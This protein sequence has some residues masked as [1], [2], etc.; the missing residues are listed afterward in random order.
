MCRMAA[1]VFLDILMATSSKIWSRFWLRGDLSKNLYG[2]R[3]FPFAYTLK[4]ISYDKTQWFDLLKSF[5]K[6][7]YLHDIFL[8]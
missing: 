6:E 3:E 4:Y 2:V 7:S 5:V 8:I 1:P